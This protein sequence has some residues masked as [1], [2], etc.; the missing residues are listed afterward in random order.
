MKLNV[1]MYKTLTNPIE[2]QNVNGKTIE[3]H[4]MNDTPYLSRYAGRGHFVIWSSDGVGYKLLVEKEYYNT[5][6][7]LHSEQTNALWLSFYEQVHK[8]RR[9]LFFK[10]MLPM[11]IGILAVMMVFSFVPALRDRNLQMPVLIGVLVVM[12][13]LN[14]FQSQLLKKKIDEVRAKTI[15]EIETTLGKEKFQELVRLQ[16]DFYENYFKFE[17]PAPIPEIESEPE[18]VLEAEIIDDEELIDVKEELEEE[19]LISCRLIQLD[20]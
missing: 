17:E 13:V 18:E 1:K 7:P 10:I 5:L 6:K 4:Y 2:V 19:W 8:I 20:F 15:E 16:N 9:S 3:V 11:L 14:M 12:L